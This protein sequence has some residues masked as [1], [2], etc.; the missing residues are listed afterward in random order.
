MAKHTEIYPKEEELQVVQRIVSHTERAL[1]QVSDQLA[2]AKPA[3]GEAAKDKPAADP[4]QKEDGRD[5][6]L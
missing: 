1:K 2:E 3:E 6:Q 4:P 5:N